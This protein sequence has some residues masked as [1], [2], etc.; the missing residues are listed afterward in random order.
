MK[1]DFDTVENFSQYGKSIAEQMI[2]KQLEPLLKN[3]TV[4]TI[5]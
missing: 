4:F 1:G 3:N 2:R 5:S